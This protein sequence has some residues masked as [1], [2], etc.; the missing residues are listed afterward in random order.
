MPE[1]RPRNLAIEPYIGHGTSSRLFL[2]G[3]VLQNLG[4]IRSAATDSRWRNLRNTFRLFATRE[5]S[6][7]RVRARYGDLQTTSV[8]DAEGYFWSEFNLRE[9]MAAGPWERVE[10]DI[11]EPN[12][13]DPVAADVLIPPERARFGVVSDIDDTVVATNVTSTFR[14][15]TTVLL[16]NAHARMPFEGIAAFY[17]A[18]MR[19]ASG[20]EG[21]PIFYVSNGPWNFHGLLVEFFKL[22]RIPLGPIFLRDFGAQVLFS[23]HSAQGDHKL[24]RIGQILALYE[25]LPFVLI[26]DS[27]E[28][29]PEIYAEIVRRFP[30][31][32]RAIYIRSVDR[33]AQRLASIAALAETVRQTPT[34]FVLASD[35][36]EA[37]AHAAGEGLI[38]ARFVPLI[39]SGAAPSL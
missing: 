5:V 32:I 30:G 13:S 24:A 4:I 39:T 37:A 18:L 29:D 3:R 33:R 20:G 25:P 34:Q 9:P 6:G 27:G 19:G 31:R 7:V 36:A 8:T 17:L 16:S 22:N 23:S 2:S 35:S 21:N 1:R 14:M 26:G 12:R 11:E 38:D 10:V 28:R 15:L